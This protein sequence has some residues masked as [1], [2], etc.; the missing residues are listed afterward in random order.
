MKFFALLVFSFLFISSS[1]FSQVDKIRFEIDGNPYL[2]IQKNYAGF[3]I[4]NQNSDQTSMFFGT[5]SGRFNTDDPGGFYDAGNSNSAYGAFSMASNTT[6]YRNTAI[7]YSTLYNNTVGSTNTAIGIFALNGNISG[8]SN[9]GIGKSALYSNTA[10]A[11]NVAIGIDALNNTN[12]A[13]RTVAVGAT[14][15][16]NDSASLDNVYVGFGAGRGTTIGTDGYDRLENVMVGSQAGYF[17]ETNGNVLLGFKAGM[18]SKADNQLYITN[19]DTDSLSSLIYG[20]FDN[21]Y[22]RFNGVVSID[23]LYSLPT[24]APTSGQYMRYSGGTQLSWGNIDAPWSFGADD[25]VVYEDGDVGIGTGNPTYR[26]EVSDNVNTGFVARF[27][28]TNNATSSRGIIIQAG[29]NT[30]PS[31][32]SYYAYFQDGNGSN[33]GGVRGNGAGGVMYSTTSDRRLKQNIKTFD[34]G[35][36]T[37]EKINPTIYQM[38]SNPSQDEIGFIAQELQKVLPIAVGGEATDDVE[39]SPMTVDYG[40]LTPV[41][42]AAVKEQQEI[43][44]AQQ[45]IIDQLNKRLDNQDAQFIQLSAEI[46]KM[47]GVTQK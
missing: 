22:L 27:H 15:G 25:D 13:N 3:Y 31:S 9:V 19:S 47:K 11:D 43:I 12:N 46:S 36:A 7:G 5:S 28:N 23:G 45:K 35:L 6:G 29:M 21:D 44:Q 1:L 33:L 20:Q 34:G 26:L 39:E 24:T 32:S 37:L 8:Y 4:I 40:R 2:S 41:I 16:V 38:K 10:G 14:A 18:F 42:V 17:C 30:N